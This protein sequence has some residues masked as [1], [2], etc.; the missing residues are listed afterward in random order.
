MKGEGG[1]RGRVD[2]G[3]RDE[4]ERGRGVAAEDLI[5]HSDGD[6]VMIW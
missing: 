1:R 3:E 4:G 5:W 2:E 6:K